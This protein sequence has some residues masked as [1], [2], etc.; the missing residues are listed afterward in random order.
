[1]VRLLA[2][3]QS[4]V[5]PQ[6]LLDRKRFL[7]VVADERLRGA[8]LGGDVVLEASALAKLL[9]AVC[10]FEGALV[11]MDTYVLTKIITT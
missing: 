4:H 1:M 6:P 11:C 8:V 9:A 10:A 5:Q 7:A 3:V 2:R